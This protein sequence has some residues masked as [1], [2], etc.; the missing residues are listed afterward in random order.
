MF[1][2]YAM[3]ASNAVLSMG[4]SELVRIIDQRLSAYVPCAVRAMLQL[5]ADYRRIFWA[6]SYTPAGPPQVFAPDLSRPLVDPS[7]PLAPC[8]EVTLNGWLPTGFGPPASE[9][10][11]SSDDSSMR[12]GQPSANGGT[13]QNSSASSSSVLPSFGV[14]VARD[15]ASSGESIGDFMSEIAD[16]ISQGELSDLGLIGEEFLETIAVSNR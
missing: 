5:S 4:G 1:G 15:G 16:E 14:P 6:L 2:T 13:S 9:I 3:R 11:W 7:P 12:D 8:R 10:E